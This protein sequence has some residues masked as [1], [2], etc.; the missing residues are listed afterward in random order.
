MWAQVVWWDPKISAGAAGET[1]LKPEQE[2]EV[3]SP[4]LL[5]VVKELGDT[6]RLDDLSAAVQGE[7]ERWLRESK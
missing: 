6:G 2:I 5:A 1:E 3:L 4:M 7:I